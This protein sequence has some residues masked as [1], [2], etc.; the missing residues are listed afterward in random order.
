M[1]LRCA[2]LR[3]CLENWLAAQRVTKVQ[4]TGGIILLAG[5]VPV[6]WFLVQP[7]SLGINGAAIATS[8]GHL[9][10]MLWMVAQTFLAMR[11]SLK[12]SWQGPS[13]RAFADWYLAGS[14]FRV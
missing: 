7:L 6:C 13:R 10:L 11:S 3:I 9:F 5:F 1:T 12:M 14:G 4:G 2:Q 8:L